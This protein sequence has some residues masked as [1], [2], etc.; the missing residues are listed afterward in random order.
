MNQK[1]GH[2]SVG[3]L[4]SPRGTGIHLVPTLATGGKDS[5]IL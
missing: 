4:Q 1:P 3:G 2:D 5:T